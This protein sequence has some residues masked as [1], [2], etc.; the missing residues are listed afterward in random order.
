MKLKEIIESVDGIFN[1]ILTHET[2]PEAARQI[3][4]SGFAQPRFGQG[5]FFNAQGLSYSGGGYGGAEVQ[6][7][8]IGPSKGILNLEDDDNLPL[9][10]DEY[11]DGEEIARYARKKGYWAWTDGM[12]FV[13]LHSRYI[14]VL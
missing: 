3:R 10:L 5:I 1:K 2:T 12:Q 6:A 14:K 7:Q 8:I 11:A 4:A 9:D 13:V